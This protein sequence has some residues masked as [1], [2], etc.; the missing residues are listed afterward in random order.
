M[1]SEKSPDDIVSMPVFTAEDEALPAQ[2]RPGAVLLRKI[3]IEDRRWRVTI[4][5]ADRRG[6][7]SVLAGLFTATGVDIRRARLTTR[8]ELRAVLDLFEVSLPETITETAVFWN[9]FEEELRELL[10]LE[11]PAARL[12]LIDRICSAMHDRPHPEHPL[13]PVAIRFDNEAAPDLTALHIRYEDTQG[14]LF[15]FANALSMLEINI[16]NAEIRT[17]GTTVRDTFWIQDT[18]RRKIDDPGKLM[19]IRAACALIKQFTHMLPLSADPGQALRQFGDLVR[20]VLFQREW[21]GDLG[22]ISSQ[23]ALNT[24]ATVMGVSRFLWED[25]LRMQH[26]NLFPLLS[27]KNALEQSFSRNDFAAAL[28]E[29]LKSAESYDERA[30]ILNKIKDRH[31]F[32]VDLQHIT[33]RIGDICFSS[34][35][36]DLADVVVERMAWLCYEHLSGQCGEPRLED[37]RPCRWAV[38]A[39]GKTGGREMGFASDIELIFVYEGAGTCAGDPALDNGRFFEKLARLFVHDLKARREGI[40]H[41]DMQLR[42]HGARGPLATSL[43]AFARYYAPSGGAAQFERMALVRLRPVAGGAELAKEVMALRD[44]F[45]Y[46]GAPLDIGEIRRLRARQLAESVTPGAINVKYGAGGLVDLEYFIQALQIRYGHELPELR[47]TNTAVALNRLQQAGIV[48]EELAERVRRVYRCLRRLID[49]LRVVRGNARDLAVPPAD[50]SD[51]GYLARRLGYTPEELT[52]ELDW[53][54]RCCENLWQ[55][56]ELLTGGPRTAPDE[57]D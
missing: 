20:Q 19:Q 18:Q 12:R 47:V 3:L 55:E 34:E 56:K 9:E 51:F 43:E 1:T 42:P 40:F 8:R 6:L 16:E 24:L 52:A 22:G 31:M 39:A 13:L 26:E 37:G 5:A 38:L 32:R 27:D 4:A 41:V 25:F 15:S 46:S 50:S 44:A 30:Q 53:S 10:R 33:G 11:A 35:L 29:E 21:A 14:F 54:M 17:D 28:D 23:R 2:L 48:G 57:A 36:S 49:A 7:L 45:V